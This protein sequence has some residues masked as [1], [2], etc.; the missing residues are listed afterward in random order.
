MLPGNILDVTLRDGGYLNQWQF[1]DKEVDAVLGYLG[2]CGI[3]RAEVGF[4]RAP[5]DGTT[6]VNGLPAE[7]L[8]RLGEAHPALGLVGMLNPA[9]PHWRAAIE[10]R[11]GHLSLIRLTCTAEVLDRALIIADAIRQAPRAPAVSVNLICISSYRHAEVA[12]LLK[13]VDGCE[14][15]DY[16]Y[17]ADSRGALAPREVGPLIALARRHCDKALGF[18]AHDTRGHAVE[19]SRVAFARGCELVDVSLNGFGLAGGN[20]PFAGL[21]A[22]AGLADAGIEE[23][24][25]AFCAQHLSLRHAPGDDRALFRALADRN[26]D[27]IWSDALTERYPGRLMSLLASLP[28]RPYKTQDE[29]VAALE[30]LVAEGSSSAE[31]Y[32]QCA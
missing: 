30:V 25:Q 11:L 21:L 8:K 32:R 14:A 16:L 29:V 4:L 9:D 15:V 28:R 10:G 22:A 6:A 23:R 19:N 18:H 17:F 27:P 2:S 5:A 13:R 7:F 1:A 31:L 26:V 24:T 12:E 3:S 20:T